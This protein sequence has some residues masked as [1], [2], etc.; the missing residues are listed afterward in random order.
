[1]MRAARVPAIQTLRMECFMMSPFAC[2]GEV[3]DL[4]KGPSRM[5]EVLDLKIRVASFFED[6]THGV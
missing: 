2:M 5:A 3:E 4:R 1:M 6:L